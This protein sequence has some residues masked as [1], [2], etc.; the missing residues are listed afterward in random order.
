MFVLHLICFILW[1]I[2]S[3]TLA[4]DNA[5][6]AQPEL[7]NSSNYIVVFKPNINSIKISNQIQRMKLHQVDSNSTITT[8][9][10]VNNTSTKNN[11]TSSYSSIGNFRWYSAQFHT[12]AIEQMLNTN[13]TTTTNNITFNTDENSAVHYYVKDATF[14]LQ[15][16][17]QTNPPSW[18]LDRIDQ[19]QG[20]DGRYSFATNQGQGVTIYLMDSGIRQDHTDIAGRVTIGKTVV[21]DSNDPSDSNGHGTFVAG[22]C[23]GTKY[24]VAKKAEIVSVK[25]LDSEGNG[26]LS[27]VL[28]GLEWI[29]EQHK[30]N[31][32]A[33]SIVK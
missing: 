30:A 2:S 18:G 4:Q 13:T 31:P 12:E 1:T 28:V 32:N 3:A 20:T 22:V 11:N 14:S 19:R 21:G 10:S 7:I 33:K 15:E 16:F 25:T 8:S 26:H 27:D 5:G 24:G 23:C 29:V 6:P 17:I 9:S